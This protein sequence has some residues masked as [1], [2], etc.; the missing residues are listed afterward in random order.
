MSSPQTPSL[1]QWV[2]VDDADPSIQYD[3]PWQHLN[4]QNLTLTGSSG[5]PYQKTLTTVNTTASFSFTFSGMSRLL[6]L[7][8]VCSRALSLYRR[9]QDR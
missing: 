7:I 8:R 1:S 6:L 5:A 2:V 4:N 3:G 9:F